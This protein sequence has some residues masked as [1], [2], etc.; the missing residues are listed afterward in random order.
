MTNVKHCLK[1]RPKSQKSC[2]QQK[3]KSKLSV[4]EQKLFGKKFLPT[5]VALTKRLAPMLF[6]G[7]ARA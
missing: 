5:A 3:N 6:L 4:I 2:R 1:L 7:T